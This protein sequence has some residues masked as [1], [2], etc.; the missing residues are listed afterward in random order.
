M[1]RCEI[2]E[3]TNKLFFR[4]TITDRRFYPEAGIKITRKET[5]EHLVEF[6][7]ACEL[8]KLIRHFFPDLLPLLKQIPGTRVILLILA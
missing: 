2:I 4:T 3:V 7:L 8:A 5:R 1:G 6:K